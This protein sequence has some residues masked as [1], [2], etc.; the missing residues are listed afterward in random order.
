MSD[1]GSFK[2][3]RQSTVWPQ[4]E[5]LA[6]GMQSVGINELLTRS[7]RDPIFIHELEEIFFDFSRSHADE[8]VLEALLALAEDMGV[9]QHIRALFDGEQV[10]C[11]ESR[12]ALHTAL[13]DDAGALQLDGEDIGQLIRQEREKALSFADAVREGQHCGYGGAR[14]RR[15]INIGIGGSDLGPRMISRALATQ[16]EPLEVLYVA[17]IDGLELADVL[18]GAEP[19]AT[20]FIICSKTFTTLET[21][22]NAEDA[23]SWLLSTL[24]EDALASNFAAVSVND[25][26]MD[27]FGISPDSRFR[28]W[29]WVGGRYSLWSAVGLGAAMSI[30]SG[31]F[32][33]LLAG[34]ATMDR[35]FLDAPAKDNLPLL[36]GLLAIWEQ[37]FMGAEQN[38]ILPYDQRLELL[39]DYLQQLFMESQGKGVRQDG[40]SVDYK[41]GAALW[42]GPG[43]NAQHS[44]SQWMHQGTTDL[45]V[46]YIGVVNAPYPDKQKAFTRALGNLVAQAETLAKGR[47]AA[48]VRAELNE[49]G[50]SDA[51]TEMLIAQKTQPGNRASKIVLMRQLNARNLGMLLAYYEHQV[52]VQAV[53]WGINPFDQWGVELGKLSATQISEKLFAKDSSGLPAI[54]P[55]ILRWQKG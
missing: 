25:V 54:G 2:N 38:L 49:Q 33:E 37:N 31:R 4:L 22:T 24:P 26:A 42:G 55:Q 34:A 13:R 41:T 48:E 19:A 36:A 11:S 6:A 23:R 44:F 15:V 53:I 51:E 46:D 7:G 32:I 29:D 14:I 35:H 39:P 1:P 16:D 20:L 47:N 30:G 45:H 12:A 52:Y 8:Q 21:R 27:E 18:Q 43:S 50:V 17:G 5:K 10:N 28:I 3:P 9:R 40:A